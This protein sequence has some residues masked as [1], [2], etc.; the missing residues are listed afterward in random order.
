MTN[1]VD[2]FIIGGGINGCGIARDAAGRGLSVTLAEKGDLASGTSSASTKLFHGGLRYLEFF[3]FRLVREALEE[4]ETLLRAMPHISW[5]MRFVLPY[6]KDM[7]FEA[8][9]PT[10]RLLTIFMPWMRGRRPAWL[11]RLGLF[12]YDTMGGR[13]ILPGTR[14]LDLHT[15]PAG[16]PLKEKYRKAYEYSDCWI[17]DSRLVVLNARDAEA[18]G[19][20][21]RTRTRVARA[22]RAGD[23]WEI[24]VES[25]DGPETHH[26]HALVNAAGP[27]AAEVIQTTIGLN[28]AD[29]VRLVRGSHIVTRKLFD[30]D[31]SYFFQG[32]DGRIIFAIPY[33]GDFTLIG[34]TDSE[35]SDPQTPPE[36]TEAEA[37]YLRHFASRYFKR[38]VTREDIVWTYS[39]V[40]PL[41]DDGASSATAATRDYVLRLETSGA[42][43][44]L[45]IF[46]GK[47]TTYRR[48]A[49]SALAELGAYFPNATGNW[50]AGVPL[51]GGDFPV[52]GV[53]KL[54][55]ALE[56][57]YPFLGPQEARRLI[58]AYGTEAPHMLGAAK[59]RADLGQEFGAGLTEAELRW[60]MAHEYA[61]RAEDVVWRR[62]RLGL[63]MSADKIAALD[64]W[65][66]A[67]AIGKARTGA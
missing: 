60:Q 30:H 43:P 51:P 17:E 42:A 14:R 25:P 37:D 45:N 33:E 10:S 1:P 18:R 46:G 36:C 40:R 53:T 63:K 24:T 4:R 58:R 48:L 11:I 26:A 6:H 35:H 16:T 67:A 22:R 62:T 19:A 21:I 39:G 31:R 12:L 38:E 5:P 64:T 47:I 57:D 44:L 8:G 7:R 13:K 9:T 29:S 61:Q 32:E 52:D 20:T 49:E 28:S 59:T 65:M 41:Y 54:T 34:T 56:Q 27:W 2:L 15:D 66:R 3:E 55:A 23:L 50:T